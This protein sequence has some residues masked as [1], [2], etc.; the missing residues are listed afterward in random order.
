MSRCEGRSV[1]R[2]RGKSR[3]EEECVGG[4]LSVKSVVDL[5]RRRRCNWGVSMAVTLPA[6]PR[7]NRTHPPVP[8]SPQREPQ[9]NR[10]APEGWRS[11]ARDRMAPRGCSA[12]RRSGTHRGG[13]ASNS[14]TRGATL[15]STTAPV[16]RWAMASK[17]NSGSSRSSSRRPVCRRRPPRVPI[18]AAL[19]E[20]GARRVVFLGISTPESEKPEIEF[21]APLDSRRHWCAFDGKDKRRGD[22]PMRRRVSGSRWRSAPP[23][24]GD[25]APT[26]L[27]DDP[28]PEAPSDD[29]EAAFSVARR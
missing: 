7:T 17:V 10:Y 8:E 19:H 15:P 6:D 9:F 2:R 3:A 21:C 11:T 14:S 26:S 27:H 24:L 29:I 25:A 12:D 23:I 28:A 1:Q 4:I 5:Y 13:R 16:R 18:V 22:P 20:V